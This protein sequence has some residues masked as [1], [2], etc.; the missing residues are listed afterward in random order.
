MELTRV[1]PRE[2][3]KLARIPRRGALL[4]SE[5]QKRLRDWLRQQG[6]AY[7]DDV[8]GWPV[9][10]ESTLHARLAPSDPPPK[11]QEWFVNLDGI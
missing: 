9:V 5:Q 11:K 1:D 10:L 2:L 3:C 6:F 4:V 7:V 8:R